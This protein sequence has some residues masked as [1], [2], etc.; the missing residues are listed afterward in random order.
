VIATNVTHSVRNLVEIAFAHAGLD[1]RRHVISDKA[2]MRP[3][4]VFHLRGDYSKAERELGWRPRVSFEQLICNMV[5]E[6]TALVK[7][8]SGAPVPETEHV[9]LT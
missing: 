9:H 7:N 8:H 2:M 6:D 3:A 4:E 1:Y 5:D